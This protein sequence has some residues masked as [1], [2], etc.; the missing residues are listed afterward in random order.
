MLDKARENALQNGFDI[1]F[2]KGDAAEL[3]FE[4]NKFDIVVSRFV[5]WTL[6]NPEAALKEWSRV[7]KAGGKIVYIDGNWYSDARPAI[8]EDM[9]LRCQSPHVCY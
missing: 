3:P 1:K 7:L 2:A 6:P 9:V 8:Q 4:D 5:L